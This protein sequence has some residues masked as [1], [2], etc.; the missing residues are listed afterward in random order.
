[1]NVQLEP[2]QAGLVPAV[3][4]MLTEGTNAFPMVMVMTLEVTLN[5]VPHAELTVKTHDT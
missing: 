5:T 1:V 2:A 3:S 4:A